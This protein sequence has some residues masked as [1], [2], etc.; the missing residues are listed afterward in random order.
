MSTQQILSYDLWYFAIVSG[1]RLWTTM[2]ADYYYESSIKIYSRERL[3]AIYIWYAQAI[4]ENVD[5]LNSYMMDVVRYWR[6]EGRLEDQ[7]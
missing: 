3:D 5:I 7:E 2:I 1:I 4:F 6:E